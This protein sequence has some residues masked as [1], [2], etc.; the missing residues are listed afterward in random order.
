MQ[1]LELP[2]THA[3]S[4]D[5]KDTCT[6][7]GHYGHVLVLVRRPSFAGPGASPPHRNC[8]ASTDDGLQQVAR[9]LVG[10]VCPA[11]RP[12]HAPTLTSTRVLKESQFSPMVGG[13]GVLVVAVRRRWRAR[14]TDVAQRETLQ[15]PLRNYSFPAD[16]LPAFNITAPR[17]LPGV[18]ITCAATI[19]G[20]ILA[21]SASLSA[22]RR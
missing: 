6:R 9:Y 14:R 5:D 11:S 1:A 15:R 7:W 4:R 12:P 20:G 17:S 22:A 18:V 21:R 3:R 16:G 8:R 10:G 13:H 19:S 2:V